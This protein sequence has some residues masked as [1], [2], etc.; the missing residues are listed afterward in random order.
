MQPRP[1]AS[2]SP[3][4]RIALLRTRFE[5]LR[6]RYGAP[7]HTERVVRMER[8]I[9][10]RKGRI[11][12][13]RQQVKQAQEELGWLEAEVSGLSKGYELLLGEMI[14]QIE[15]EYIKET[16]S[17]VPVLGY[18]VWDLR[19]DGLHG[20][21]VRWT[22][23]E[24][25]AVCLYQGD[26]DDVPHSDERCGRL[27]CGVYA[28][29]DIQALLKG[30]LSGEEQGFAVGLVALTGKVIEHERGY[31]AAHARVIALAASGATSIFADPRVIADGPI[32]E[33]TWREVHDCIAQYLSDRARRNQW[34]LVSKKE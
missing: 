20:V 12:V 5:R 8:N 18:R 34:T 19:A 28:A 3:T 15:K 33:G 13:L 24:M 23:P 4:D 26:V 1:T 2:P 29:K 17:P 22:S 27:G 10:R 31:R 11:R 9:K 16:W 6:R 21:K 25:N 7:E 30:F 32:R 14:R